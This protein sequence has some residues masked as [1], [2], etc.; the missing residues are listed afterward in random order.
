MVIGKV[1]LTT[2]AAESVE[3]VLYCLTEFNSTAMH[4]I[5]IKTVPILSIVYTQRL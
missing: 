4:T 2:N 1:F 5:T 3:D